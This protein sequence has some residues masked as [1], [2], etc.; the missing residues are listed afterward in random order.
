MNEPSKKTIEKNANGEF[1]FTPYGEFLSYFH[2]HLEIFKRF[3]RS[4]NYTT[5]QADGYIKKLKSYMASNVKNLDQYFQ[6][7]P[8]FAG[9]LDVSSEELSSYLNKNFL[10]TLPIVQEKFRL[11][12][13]KKIGESPNLDFERITEEIIESTGFVFPE[14]HH[15]VVQ[16]NLVVL[17]NLKTGEI[18]EP[19][20]LMSGATVNQPAVFGADP[21]VEKAV[22][23][24][25]IPDRPILEEIVQ[26]FGDDLAGT[27]LNLSHEI[28][29]EANSESKLEDL[30][31]SQED[32]LEDIEDLDF[33]EPESETEDDQSNV[34]DDIGDIL[35]FGNEDSSPQ[36]PVIAEDILSFQLSDFFKLVQTIQSFQ[37]NKDTEG[38]QTWMKTASDLIKLVVSIRTNHIKEVKGEMVSWSSILSS[39][40]DKVS[41]N[42]ES[43]LAIQEKVIH[44]NWVKIG[45]DRAIA[46]LKKG[47][48][49][50][51]NL[52]K[53]AWPH[54]QKAFMESP[55]YD[56]VLGQLKLVIAKVKSDLHRKE[57]VRVMT[58]TLNYLK[59][60]YPSVS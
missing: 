39:F 60:K 50:F 7:I 14:D 13:V 56:S 5:S 47:D 36:V 48:P 51:L 4:K 8:N 43:I 25:V 44:F 40:E 37:N 19:Q 20:G 27:E 29:E 15:F 31:I 16:G 32:V 23:T 45:L 12:E 49:E 54:L 42:K 9:I 59:S 26:L 52:V 34:L 22:V 21:A 1:I 2:A 46:E 41:Y 17:E 18:K 24:K 35:G 3:C 53:M 30:N 55:D 28:E 11:T 58:M 33:E 6:H 38:Y 57:L 10:E